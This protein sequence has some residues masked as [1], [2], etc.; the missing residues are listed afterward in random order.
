MLETMLNGIDESI[1]K[2][3]RRLE[4]RWQEWTGTSNYYLRAIVSGVSSGL[5][6]ADAIINS[7]YAITAILPISF[8]AIYTATNLLSRKSKLSPI[9]YGLLAGLAPSIRAILAQHG[10][11]TYLLQS[12]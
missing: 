1:A 12:V 8:N 3:H 2:S 4:E 10:D 5:Y 9:F 11:S 7:Q 6:L